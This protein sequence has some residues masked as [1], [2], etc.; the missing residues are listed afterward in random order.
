V[1]AATGSVDQITSTRPKECQLFSQR[2]EI[3][4]YTLNRKGKMTS[5]E[6]SDVGSRLHSER[7]IVLKVG[8]EAQH[9]FPRIFGQVCELPLSRGRP[10]KSPLRSSGQPG[11]P[12]LKTTAARRASHF[13]SVVR[14]TPR[15]VVR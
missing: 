2:N 13:E 14:G 3:E 8:E 5:Y 6:P 7:P 10:P 12:T 4:G 15:V 9:S 11:T 1:G